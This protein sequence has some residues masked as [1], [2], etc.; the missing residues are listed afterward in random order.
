MKLRWMRPA[1]DELR[2]YAEEIAASSPRAAVEVIDRLIDA[3]ESLRDLEEK[4]RPIGDGLSEL[5]IPGSR[6]AL[7]YRLNASVDRL[8]ILRIV[9]AEEAWVR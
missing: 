1:L 4:G 7:I 5:R 8:E 2:R 9:Q 3:A 6:L